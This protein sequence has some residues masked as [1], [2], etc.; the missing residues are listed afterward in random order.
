M[1]DTKRK[2]IAIILLWISVVIMIVHLLTLDYSNFE[3][4]DLLGPLSNIL[5]ILAMYFTIRDI[6]KKANN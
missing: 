3:Y 1:E 4:M 6:N 5:L 2:K